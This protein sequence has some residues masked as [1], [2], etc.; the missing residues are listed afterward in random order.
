MSAS[1]YMAQEFIH[2]ARSA[3]SEDLQVVEAMVG[4]DDHNV[5][6]ELAGVEPLAKIIEGIV[7]RFKFQVSGTVLHVG[8]LHRESV[9]PN[10]IGIELR[11]PSFLLLNMD[12]NV[13]KSVGKKLIIDDISIFGHDQDVGKFWLGFFSNLIF[14][15]STVKKMNSIDLSI[16]GSVKKAK[17]IASDVVLSYIR[18]IGLTLEKLGVDNSLKTQNVPEDLSQSTS[19]SLYEYFN[20]YKAFSA[21]VPGGFDKTFTA[22]KEE[23]TPWMTSAEVVFAQIEILYTLKERARFLDGQ[24]FSDLKSDFLSLTVQDGIFELSQSPKATEISCK[25][26]CITH[27]HE[28]SELVLLQSIDNNSDVF[29]AINSSFSSKRKNIEILK[30]INLNLNRGI[31]SKLSSAFKSSNFLKSKSRTSILQ[32]DIDRVETALNLSVCKVCLIF[33]LELPQLDAVFFLDFRELHLVSR[34]SWELKFQGGSVSLKSNGKNLFVI[35]GLDNQTKIISFSSIDDAQLCK[36][37]LSEKLESI[38]FFDI[39]CPEVS[40]DS[41]WLDISSRRKFDAPK[42]IDLFSLK[43]CKEA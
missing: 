31:I 37:D 27:Y 30:P 36:V 17:I 38:S 26:L 32:N 6:E 21:D 12:D 33:D 42:T 10:L 19:K 41:D 8:T 7:N 34:E 29:C 16:Y 1:F 40:R 9:N 5:Q 4:V 28:N 14:K 18:D 3:S 25:N 13:E 35:V 23:S 22:N 11:I 43:V 20:P 15:F 24:S 39:G 2:Q